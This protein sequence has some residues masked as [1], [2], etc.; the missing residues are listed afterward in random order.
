MSLRA[1]RLLPLLLGI[2]LLVPAMAA[3][4][5]AAAEDQTSAEALMLKKLNYE[6]TKR[7]LVALRL[8]TRIA[9]IARD[10]SEYQA[11]TGDADALLALP[12]AAP[13]E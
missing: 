7:G 2:A 13:S 5:A 10:R 11:R 1:R 12:A 8:D 9:A 6:R 3:A 4:P